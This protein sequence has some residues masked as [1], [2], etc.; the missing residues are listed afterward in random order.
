MLEMEGQMKE[1]SGE[2]ASMR[3]VS[4]P[5]IMVYCNEY[6]YGYKGKI[7]KHSA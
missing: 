6:L 1:W 3:L 5:L 4:M 7:M 2:D